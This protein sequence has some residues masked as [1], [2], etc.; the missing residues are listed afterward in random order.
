MASKSDK[1][2][3]QTPKAPKAPPQ[4]L[5]YE[6][7][8]AYVGSHKVPDEAVTIRVDIPAGLF[9]NGNPRLNKVLQTLSFVK[10]VDAPKSGAAKNVREPGAP[11]AGAGTLQD[12]PSGTGAPTGTTD[13]GGESTEKDKT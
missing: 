10:Q 9:S 2:P 1:A 5:F 11:S 7:S 3:P 4:V 8:R 13:G 6:S 12:P